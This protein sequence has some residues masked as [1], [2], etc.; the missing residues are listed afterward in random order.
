MTGIEFLAQAV[1]LQA[2]A[3][4]VLLTAY[5]DTDVA[6]KAINDIRLDHYILKPWDPPEEKLYPITRRPAGR[7][8]LHLPALHRGAAPAGR[9]L[10]AGRARDPRLP[11][12]QPGPVPVDRPGRGR[13]GPPLAATLLEAHPDMAPIEASVPIVIF[14]DGSALRDPVDPRDRREGRPADAGR[15]ALLRPGHRGRRPGRPGGGGVRRQRGPQDDPDR[16]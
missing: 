13:G 14:P 3:S 2:D 8:D 1:E 11:D 9:P 7:L 10:G 5:A 6:I 15:A 16:A 4:R 12:P